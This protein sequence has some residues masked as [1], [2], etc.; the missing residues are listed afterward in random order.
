MT[1]EIIN[2]YEIQFENRIIDFF[3][4]GKRLGKIFKANNDCL[5]DFLILEEIHL[6][7]KK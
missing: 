7:L 5:S 3:L 2:Q 4:L 6:E 1:Q